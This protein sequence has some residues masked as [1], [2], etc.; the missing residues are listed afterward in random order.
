V[1]D[2]LNKMS[3][4]CSECPV[5]FEYKDALDHSKNCLRYFMKSL[6]SL[7]EEHAKTKKEQADLE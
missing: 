6:V 5:K 7:K 4:K 1:K 3:F 2:T